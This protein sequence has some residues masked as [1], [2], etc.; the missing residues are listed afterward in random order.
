MKGI[1][2]GEVYSDVS[3]MVMLAI[4]PGMLLWGPALVIY[5]ISS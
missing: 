3:F 5:Y 1:D 4:F 2:W